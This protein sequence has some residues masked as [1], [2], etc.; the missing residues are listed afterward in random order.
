M[1]DEWDHMGQKLGAGAKEKK[2]I[3]PG[4][5]KELNFLKGRCKIL[6]KYTQKGDGKP[7]RDKV[8]RG[9]EH[10]PAKHLV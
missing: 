6:K 7:I 1:G 8:R 10:R 2:V 3:N 4:K 9:V 5:E